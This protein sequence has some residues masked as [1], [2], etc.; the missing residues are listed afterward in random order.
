MMFVIMQALRVK[1]LFCSMHEYYQ[2]NRR[3]KDAYHD[4]ELE[5]EERLES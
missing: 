3:Q 1:P 2:F 4:E 5:A